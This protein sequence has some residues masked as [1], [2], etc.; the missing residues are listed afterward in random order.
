MNFLDLSKFI[1][2]IGK[3]YNVPCYDICI[4]YDHVNVF[5][6]KRITSSFSQKLKSI[7]RNY[8][9]MQSGTKIMTCVALM[10]LIQGYKASL[11]DMVCKY[12]PEFPEDVTLRTMIREYSRIYDSDEKVFSFVNMRKLIATIANMPFEEYVSLK[13]TGPLKMKHTT[14]NLTS[15]SRKK[16][17]LQYRF[18]EA[19]EKFVAYDADVDAIAKRNDGCIIT[20]VDD[21]AKFCEAMCS[22]GV[23]QNGYQL[24]TKESVD[25]LINEL[26]YKETEKNDAFVS[27]GRHGCLVL[28]DTKKKI[29][30]VYAQNLKNM[31]LE[32]LEMYPKLRK[33]VY[34]C[35]GADTWSMG[36]NVLP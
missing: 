7:G 24:L 14:F 18:D 2:S 4:Y 21:Y 5:R 12:L 28:I 8:Y 32:Q 23:A 9:F 31:P 16:I 15:K 6:S 13:I 22:G 26:I 1:A 10:R 19:T 30:I 11:N 17:A 36:Y 27:I 33:L 29:S 34:E 35:I 25:L 3:T 20:T